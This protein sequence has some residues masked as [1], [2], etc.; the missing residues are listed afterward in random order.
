MKLID[1][2]CSHFGCEHM[3]ISPQFCSHITTVEF[4]TT[5]T[6][7]HHLVA[8]SDASLVILGGVCGW[9]LQL[10]ANPL[11]LKIGGQVFT[12]K[13][14]VIISQ[15]ATQCQHCHLWVLPEAI[16]KFSTDLVARLTATLPTANHSSKEPM[17]ERP[18]SGACP[19]TGGTN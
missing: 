19:T 9:K 6:P 3:T 18:C 7:D 16:E 12:P 1:F 17:K 14:W 2:E 15:S 8:I 5:T 10:S 13:N 11:K 4:T